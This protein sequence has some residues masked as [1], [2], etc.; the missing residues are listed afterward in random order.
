MQTDTTDGAERAKASGT[1]APPGAAA[2]SG[3]LDL[4]IVNIWG[5]GVRLSSVW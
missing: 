4:G 2:G 3:L 1:N 5:W